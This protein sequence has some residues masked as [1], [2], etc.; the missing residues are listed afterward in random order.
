M[1]WLIIVY[2]IRGQ[3]L[4][5]KIFGHPEFLGLEDRNPLK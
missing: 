4:V 1:Y 2:I 3:H 5:L